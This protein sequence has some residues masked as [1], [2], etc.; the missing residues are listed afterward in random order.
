MDSPQRVRASFRLFAFVVLQT[1]EGEEGEEETLS[2]VEPE[3]SPEQQQKRQE[4]FSACEALH[5]RVEG[6]YRNTSQPVR[7]CTTGWKVG[8]GILLSQRFCAPNHTS[9]KLQSSAK[10]PT[11]GLWF[12][13]FRPRS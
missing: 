2:S 10:M 13:I 12:G 4:Y 5:H 8:A 3:E 11:T 9:S 1:K 7:L 6:W